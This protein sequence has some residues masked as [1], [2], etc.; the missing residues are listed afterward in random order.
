[1][2]IHEIINDVLNKHL[3]LEKVLKLDESQRSI[4]LSLFNTLME[5]LKTDSNRGFQYNYSTMSLVYNN[6]VESGYLVTR[7][8]RNLNTLVD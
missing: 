1:M 2:D 7:R 5:E 3:D 8:E 4:V 6:L